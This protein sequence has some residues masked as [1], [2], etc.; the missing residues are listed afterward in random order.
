MN[1]DPPASF[2]GFQTVI[3]HFISILL[4]LGGA[5]VLV[6]FLVGGFQ[7]LLAAGD[8]EATAKAQRSLQ[9][10]IWGLVII[11]SSWAI[12]NLLGS[13]LGVDFSVFSICLPGSPN[14]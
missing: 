13:F 5:A 6:M 11:V 12:I 1:A 2:T 9:W 4:S 7:Y 3:E 14:C 8:K 10:T